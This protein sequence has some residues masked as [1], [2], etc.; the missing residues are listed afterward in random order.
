[1]P[2]PEL[3]TPVRPLKDLHPQFINLISHDVYEPARAMLREVCAEF[4]DPDGNF[5][6]QFQTNGFDARTFELFLF[7]MFKDLGHHIE[8][9]RRLD[10]ILSRKGQTACV[11]AVVASPP[12]NHGIIPYT[13]DAPTRSPEE[14]QGYLE[15]EMA[16]RL[17]SPLF[18]KLQ[19]K[20]WTL[21]QTQGKPLIF[22][23]EN[24]H[25]GALHFGDTAR[26][27]VPSG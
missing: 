3:L 17:G 9:E 22:A 8:R 15:Q 5:V 1:M 20:Y 6:E 23:I 4:P 14:L 7:A 27:D 25:A 2:K 11:E 12:P 13:H 18:S 26:P 24:F 10:F 16:I 21:P 19:K